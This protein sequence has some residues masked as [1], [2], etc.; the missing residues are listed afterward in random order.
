MSCS[1]SWVYFKIVQDVHFLAFVEPAVNGLFK[2]FS[3][4][5]LEGIKVQMRHA[6]KILYTWIFGE[7]VEHKM[8]ER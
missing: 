5:T 1:G 8:L 6:R 7:M 2:L 4:C 3:E